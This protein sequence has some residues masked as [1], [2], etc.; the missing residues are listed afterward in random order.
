MAWTNTQKQ[1]AARAC[2]AAR[3]SDEQRRDMILRN[4]ERAHTAN[5]SITSTAPRLTNGDFEQFMAIV[6][7]FAGGRVL[8]YPR[9]HWQA[10]AMDNL[11]RMRHRAARVAVELERAGHLH[12]DGAGLA[13]WIEKRVSKGEATRIE[14]LDFHQLQALIIGLEAYARHRQ[15]ALSV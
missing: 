14:Q 11:K 6:E 7:N 15:L 3:I 2:I 12:A 9:G 1:I 8:H 4:F 10:A 13:G 5:G